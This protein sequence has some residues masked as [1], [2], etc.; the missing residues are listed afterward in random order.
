MIPLSFQT[1]DPLSSQIAWPELHVAHVGPVRSWERQEEYKWCRIQRAFS[2]RVMQ[3]Q[4]HFT[5]AHY[6]VAA[7]IPSS[8]H[9]STCAGAESIQLIYSGRAL[10]ALSDLARQ[11]QC[12]PIFWRNCF[13]TQEF[14]R[15][16][17]TGVVSA[18]SRALTCPFKQSNASVWSL[19]KL[20]WHLTHTH[21]WVRLSIF[22]KLFV[23]TVTVPPNESDYV[24]SQ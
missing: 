7:V 15:F 18:S 13:N 17:S 19:F 20:S 11:F 12:Q 23:S 5:A 6:T 9:P 3:K 2:R 24:N 14:T 1:A 21:L 4:P 8:Q 16:V 10:R 22:L